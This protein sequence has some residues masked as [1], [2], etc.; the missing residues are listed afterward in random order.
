MARG[1]LALGFACPEAWG[2][3]G[4]FLMSLVVTL[5]EDWR[6]DRRIKGRVIQTRSGP[7]IDQARNDIVSAFL[8]HPDHPDWLL[9]LDADMVWS[10]SDVRKLFEAADEVERPVIGGLCFAGHRDESQMWPTIFKAVEMEDGSTDIQKLTD[11]PK[12]AVCKVFGT[13][14]AFL[15]MHRGALERFREA[16]GENHPAPWFFISYLPANRFGE[17]VSM[18]I[19]AQKLGIPIH[20]H[21]GVRI[22]HVKAR[23]L[24]EAVYDDYR[25]TQ[26]AAKP[27]LTLAKEA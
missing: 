17:D 19:R 18:C 21:T 7:M 27:L 22:G 16:M 24:T 20:V 15:L 6:T 25:A 10:P 4:D 13:G 3:A 5:N 2:G 8:A 14:A 9:M 11:Y 26:R 23:V 12:D 1:T